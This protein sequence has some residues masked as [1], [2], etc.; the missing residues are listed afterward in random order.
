MSDDA[1][2]SICV[3]IIIC[4][5]VL[6]GLISHLFTAR[7]ESEVEEDNPTEEEMF[8]L[9]YQT[10]AGRLLQGANPETIEVDLNHI[11]SYDFGEGVTAAYNRWKEVVK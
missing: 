4:L 10:A 5:I 2:T 8:Q 1:V 7:S 6:T 9:G 3:T 11:G